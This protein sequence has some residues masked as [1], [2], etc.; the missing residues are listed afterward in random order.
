MWKKLA[1]WALLILIG[2]GLVDCHLRM[3]KGLQDF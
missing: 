3:L 1:A 2:Y